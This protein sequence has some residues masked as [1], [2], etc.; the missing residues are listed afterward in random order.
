MTRARD[1]L[2]VQTALVLCLTATGA[3]SDKPKMPGQPPQQI[4]ALTPEDQKRLR[5]QR[6]VVEKYLA[7]ETS[8][9]KYQTAVGKLGLIRAVLNA[10]V[11][12]RPKPTKC[13]A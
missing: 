12:S 13:S 5:D 7:D 9:Q 11:F 2:L 4:T 10:N 3:P 8:R 6:A 1:L